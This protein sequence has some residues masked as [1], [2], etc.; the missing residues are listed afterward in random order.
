MFEVLRRIRSF[1]SWNFGVSNVGS[2]DRAVQGRA[3]S[4]PVTLRGQFLS[5]A[6]RKE[7]G[8]ET[9]SE[10]EGWQVRNGDYL[11]HN[12]NRNL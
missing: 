10:L 1:V 4:L 3:S 11:Q 9:F 2:L 6:C 7:G 12:F 5:L 8:V